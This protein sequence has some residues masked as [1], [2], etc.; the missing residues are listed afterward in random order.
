MYAPLEISEI[1]ISEVKIWGLLAH[2]PWVIWAS[3]PS[4]ERLSLCSKLDCFSTTA[5]SVLSSPHFF[6]VLVFLGCNL[7]LLAYSSQNIF[8]SEYLNPVGFTLENLDSLNLH[9]RSVAASNTMVKAQH[10]IMV[11]LLPEERKVLGRVISE[12]GK[13][14]KSL[15][16]ES[17]C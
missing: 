15:M 9:V 16:G 8:S 17:R 12:L 14:T 3:W 10:H 11:S 2:M 7:S 5:Y 13:M 1:K 6:L 4:Y